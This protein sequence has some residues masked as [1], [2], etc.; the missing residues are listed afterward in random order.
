MG[1][2]DEAQLGPG[3]YHRE[4][5]G[6]LGPIRWTGPEAIAY[7][8]GEGRARRVHVRAYSGEAALGPVAGRL[9]VE[10]LAPEGAWAPLGERAV[11]LPADTWEEV[12]L[13][14][15][16]TEGP[17]RVTLRVDAPRVPRDLVPGS[18]DSRALGFA[19]TRL[20]LA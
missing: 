10:A 3:W 6:R 13:D 11:T 8:R 18:Q 12:T 1:P 7:L 15:P 5:W 16:G 14:L 19:V 2:G 4:V 9:T 20:W 17:L